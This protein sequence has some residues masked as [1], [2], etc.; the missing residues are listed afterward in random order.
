MRSSFIYLDLFS[1]SLTYI[2]SKIYLY[3]FRFL[4]TLHVT[5]NRDILN[6]LIKPER[7]R[8]LLKKE[9]SVASHI[10][11][12]PWNRRREYILSPFLF[13]VIFFNVSI[14]HLTYTRRWCIPLISH[15]PSSHFLP[16]LLWWWCW[17]CQAQ[18][19]RQ[20][21]SSPPSRAVFPTDL[22]PPSWHVTHDFCFYSKMML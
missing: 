16:G 9:S 19:E 22:L 1:I 21:F 3:N 5:Q 14:P 2:Y 4:H 17:W 13:I 18:R 11:R 12:R 20:V 6:I 8:E 7:K 10:S 15:A